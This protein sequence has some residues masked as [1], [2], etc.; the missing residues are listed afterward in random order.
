MFHN[1]LKEKKTI[2][3][4][5][6]PQNCLKKSSISSDF[7]PKSVSELLLY[8]FTLWKEKCQFCPEI[9]NTRCWLHANITYSPNPKVTDNTHS[10]LQQ[11]QNVGNLMFQ[12]KVTIQS[13]SQSVLR[14]VL[15][16]YMESK[17]LFYDSTIFFWPF[18]AHRL[19]FC[20]LYCFK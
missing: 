20:I 1:Y 5:I 14:S 12:F 18:P 2:F 13:V 16:R 8:F 9:Y 15:S 3:C 7:L 17:K 10:K 6:L 11:L 4:L 19:I